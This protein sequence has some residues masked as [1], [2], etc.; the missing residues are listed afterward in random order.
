MDYKE[1]IAERL[2]ELKLNE[3]EEILRST[4]TPFS[5]ITGESLIENFV[6]GKAIFD[7]DVLINSF[8]DLL[9]FEIKSA[10]ILAAQIIAVCIFIGLLKSISSS[11]GEKTVSNIGLLVCS[12]FVIALCMKNFT[13]TYD[14]CADTIA[15]MTY[16]MQILLPI[17]IPLLISMGG[18]T[19]GSLLNPLM[20]ASITAFNTLLLKVMLPM[21]FVSTVFF[22]INGMT[23]KSYVKTLASFL[24]SAAAIA[25]G[26]CATIFSGLTLIQGFVA[27]SADGLLINTARF[28]LSNFV[29]I[30]GGF[31][32]DSVDMV[33]SCIAI[34]KSGIGVLGIIV[35]CS[36]LIMPIIK[37]LALAIIYKFTAIITEPIGEKNISE[38][39]NE[40]GNAT[41]T[42]VVIL[43]LTSMMF[44]IFIS[45]LIGIGGA[46]R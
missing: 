37:L 38:S 11:F 35:I 28:S 19:S 26:F 18:I 17:L 14:L 24:R 23:E 32:A 25:T 30:V 20:I 12:F 41:A 27:K 42:L 44:L 22:L 3:L 39:L 16:T 8:K 46:A 10:M 29:P 15:T 36:L 1:Y 45:V 4:E 21:I 9:L 31:A 33:L 7:T 40:M 13:Y 6:S 34:I 43:I 2:N 5:D